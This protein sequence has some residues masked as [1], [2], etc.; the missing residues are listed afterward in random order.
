MEKFNKMIGVEY[1]RYSSHSQDPISTEIQ[2]LHIQE[3]AKAN[4]IEIIKKYIDEA[5]TGTNADRDAFQQLI[6][7]ANSSVFKV[8]LVYNMSRFARDEFDA[9]FYMKELEKKGIKIIS[10]QEQF[11]DTP[12][13]E[14]SKSMMIAFNAYYSRE[15]HQKITRHYE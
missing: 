1:T 2:D 11:Q 8:V 7:D 10:V 3:Y 15:L 14:F 5:K 13:G 4:N 12:Q 9:Y 6:F